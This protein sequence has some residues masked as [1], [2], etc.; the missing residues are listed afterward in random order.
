MTSSPPHTQGPSTVGEKATHDRFHLTPTPPPKVFPGRYFE[1]PGAKIDL[2][3]KLE[4]K[5]E[6]APLPFPSLL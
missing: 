3:Q 2:G 4:Q 6:K 1:L 5:A